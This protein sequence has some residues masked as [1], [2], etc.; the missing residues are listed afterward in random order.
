MPHSA[1]PAPCV[2]MSPAPPRARARLRRAAGAVS[3]S[4]PSIPAVQALPSPASASSPTARTRSRTGGEGGQRAQDSRAAGT[5]MRRCSRDGEQPGG[6]DVGGHR[7]DRDPHQQEAR[8][9]GRLADVGGIGGGQGL[10]R[11]RAGGH[12]QLNSRIRLVG[13][14]ARRLRSPARESRA[15][16]PRRVARAGRRGDAEPQYQAGGGEGQCIGGARRG[17]ARSQAAGRPRR[18]PRSAPTGP[19][20]AS[21]PGQGHSGGR[22]AAPRAAPP[23]GRPGRPGRSAPWRT[24]ARAARAA[25][26]RE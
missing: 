23:S 3:M 21:A 16:D 22:V 25:A 15:I 12:S 10:G 20:S 5:M 6:D 11:D 14:W 19:P 8:G 4:R 9:P 1:K 17:V 26:S 7:P 24:T 18:N 13:R 2:N